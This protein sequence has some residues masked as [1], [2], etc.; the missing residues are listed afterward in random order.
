MGCE[1][2]ILSV[3]KNFNSQ[4]LSRTFPIIH[5][6]PDRFQCKTSIRKVNVEPV[7]GDV[8]EV[9]LNNARIIPA[10]LVVVGVGIVPNTQFIPNP[11][12]LGW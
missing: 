7:H 3:L 12:Q 9:V 10:C 2:I 5:D 1:T 4:N 11:P 6:S 8:Y